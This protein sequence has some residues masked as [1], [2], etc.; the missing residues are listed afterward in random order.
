MKRSNQHILIGLICTLIVIVILACITIE[1]KTVEPSVDIQMGIQEDDVSVLTFDF[2]IINPNQREATLTDF[3]YYVYLGCDQTG[4]QVGIE[5]TIAPLKHKESVTITRNF[6]IPH[7][8]PLKHFLREGYNVTVNGSLTGTVGSKPFEVTFEN[9]TNIHIEP[10][11]DEE[12]EQATCPDITGMELETRDSG[13]N[14]SIIISNPNQVAVY[15]EEL[16]YDVYIKK[17][18][19]WE[20][21]YPGGVFGGHLIMPNESY[22]G[23]VEMEISEN[24]LQYL[25][26]SSTDVKVEGTMFSF[27]KE[28]GWSPIYFESPVEE[29]ITIIDGSGAIGEA[30]TTPAPSP[31]AEPT[32][33]PTP[34]P[35]LTTTSELEIVVNSTGTGDALFKLTEQFATGELYVSFKN[36]YSE[37]RAK[38]ASYICAIFGVEEVR[39]IEDE[40]D[41]DNYIYKMSFEV[42]GFTTKTDDGVWSSTEI[43]LRRRPV[44]NVKIYFPE[45][46][47]IEKAEDA[48]VTKNVCEWIGTAT[49]PSIFAIPSIEYKVPELPP[50]PIIDIGAVGEKF[51]SFAQT[52]IL[53][54]SE[55]LLYPVIIILFILIGWSLIALGGFLYEWHARNRDFA[56]LER[57]AL[58]AKVLLKANEVDT[59]FAVLGE[60]CS[61]NFVHDFLGRLAGFKRVFSSEKFMEVKVEK[62]LQDFE[63]EMTRRLEKSRLVT[64]A[65]PMLGLMGTLIPMGP[66]LLALAGGDLETLANNLII[67]F[68]TTVLGL[69]TGLVGHLVTM[70]RSRWYEQDMS[71]MEYLSEILFGES[72]VEEGLEL[73]KEED[74]EKRDKGLRRYLNKV[75][76]WKRERDEKG[77]KRE[78]IDS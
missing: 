27:P 21:L 37:E 51:K 30:V 46:S 26:R 38:N 36:N 62:L 34:T 28:K 68:G 32:A 16:E 70:V 23:S 54:I 45:G 43:N 69:A 13:I 75:K 18:G 24:D 19:K 63:T 48:T 12:A 7:G 6:S 22:K 60:G 3:E 53:Y 59:A 17:G 76:G 78:G 72:V 1:G 57:A 73:G 29:V 50:E 31:P 61:N 20:S 56:S 55:G 65:G 11:P 35:A 64:R 41:D 74:G 2:I 77:E 15:F 67:A 14:M 5:E 66:A 42:P 52:V 47:E 9:T 4:H 58:K 71:D 49:E 44:N 33:E 40:F 8:E 25:K 10:E 39:D